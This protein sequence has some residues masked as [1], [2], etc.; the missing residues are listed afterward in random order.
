MD[1]MSVMNVD[2][3]VLSQVGVLSVSV[4]LAWSV[5]WGAAHIA[6]VDLFL[7]VDVRFV[8]PFSN[9]SARLLAEETSSDDFQ[10]YNYA[11][12]FSICFSVFY[13]IQVARSLEVKL[14]GEFKN[15]LGDPAVIR[16][17]GSDEMI[18]ASMKLTFG[19]AAIV[20][21]ALGWIRETTFVWIA[22][23]MVPR[24][25]VSFRY[26]LI[27]SASWDPLRCQP[28]TL[29][30]G[31]PQHLPAII[32]RSGEWQMLMLGEGVLQIII[33]PI[34]DDHATT[35]NLAFGLSFCVLALLQLTQ[36]SNVSK[37]R[38]DV[39]IYCGNRI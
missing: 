37:R 20:T 31:L 1:N 24:V 3:L 35:H 12:G 5:A 33:Q 26:K 9:S 11:L 14:F 10:G 28:R 2:N 18:L 32:K 34:P 36:F 22:L 19:I 13:A 15:D 7:E 16:S 38:H 6:S 39:I 17:A 21:S 4:S 25:I 29:Y 23:V 30:S 27:R 8:A